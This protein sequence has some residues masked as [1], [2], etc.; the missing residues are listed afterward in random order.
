VGKRAFP[1]T[2][3]EVLLAHGTGATASTYL[4]P[5]LLGRLRARHPDLELVVVTGNSAEMAAAVTAAD[6]DVAVVT[7][8]ARGRVCSSTVSTTS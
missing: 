3:G 6:V 5:P 2:A 4:L 7:L 1:T 8:P